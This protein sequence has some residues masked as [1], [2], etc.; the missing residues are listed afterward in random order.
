MFPTVLKQIDFSI[1]DL[2]RIKYRIDRERIIY[3]RNEHFC[4]HVYNVNKFVRISFV[5]VFPWQGSLQ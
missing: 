4:L 1:E 3:E 2:Y 5:V